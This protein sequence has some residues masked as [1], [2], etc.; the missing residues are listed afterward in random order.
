[1]LHG[2]TRIRWDESLTKP[3]APADTVPGRFACNHR[4]FRDPGG[5]PSERPSRKPND[6]RKFATVRKAPPTGLEPVTCRLTAGRST[7]EL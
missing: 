5:R 6:R 7:I 4:D 2:K 1:M 3:R